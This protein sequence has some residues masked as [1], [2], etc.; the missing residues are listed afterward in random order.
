MNRFRPNIVVSG[1]TAFEED[2]LESLTL[3]NLHL[4]AVKPCAR[5]SVPSVDQTTGISTGPE[6]PA[7]LSEFRQDEQVQGVTFGQNLIVTG[8]VG[9]SLQVGARLNVNLNF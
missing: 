5:C 2:F 7:T 8:G 1:L 4:R 6:P 9:T 3:G